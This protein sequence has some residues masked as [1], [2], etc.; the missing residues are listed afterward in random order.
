M[1]TTVIPIDNGRRGF[2]R[3]RE[4][5]GLAV[6]LWPCGT[7]LSAAGQRACRQILE[8]Y[9]ARYRAGR[10]SRRSVA[11]DVGATSISIT[12]LERVARRACLDELLLVVL[13][14]LAA[15]W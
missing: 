9:G 7:D 15:A 11:V 4:Q 14:D 3:V 1:T 6:D 12:P 13:D 10:R 2:I 5:R 8:R